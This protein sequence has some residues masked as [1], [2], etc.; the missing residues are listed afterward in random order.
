[1]RMKNIPAT[2]LLLLSACFLTACGG[3]QSEALGI[4]GADHYNDKETT[5]AAHQSATISLAAVT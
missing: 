5:I 2:T 3:N 4:A 1:M